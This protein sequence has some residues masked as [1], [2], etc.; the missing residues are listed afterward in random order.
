MAVKEAEIIRKSRKLENVKRIKDRQDWMQEAQYAYGRYSITVPVG[1]T[2]D[3]ILKPEAWALV[4]HRLKPQPGTGDS[5]RIGTIFEVR[6]QDHQWYAELYVRAVREMALD[7]AILRE[8]VW[9]APKT[10]DP[11]DYEV[12]WNI[13]VKGF[14]IIRKVD[15]EKVGDGRKFPKKEDAIEYLK[16]I[17]G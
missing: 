6:T 7:V 10:D 8:P 11:D 15:R 12:K 16:R 13:S 9:L 5:V 17:T 1:W 14:D 2:L 4:A 3:D